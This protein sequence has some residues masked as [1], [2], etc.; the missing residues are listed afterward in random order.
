MKT[1]VASM[2]GTALF[3]VLLATALLLIHVLGS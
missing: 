2:A 3:L 1:R